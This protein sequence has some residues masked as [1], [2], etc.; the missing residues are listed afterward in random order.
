M[1]LPGT[2]SDQPTFQWDND[3]TFGTA[4]P[5]GNP[6]DWSATPTSPTSANISDLQVLCAVT[7]SLDSESGTDAGEINS[8]K[9]ILTILD[10]EQQALVSHGG[11]LMPDR[12]VVKGV[13]YTFDFMTVQGLFDVDVYTVHASSADA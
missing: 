1:G 5:A 8:E 3:P 11:G 13:T 12:V 6:W 7:Y 4:D 9:V 10:T 2:V